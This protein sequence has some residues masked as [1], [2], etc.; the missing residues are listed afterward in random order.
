MSK[1]ALLCQAARLLG[2]VLAH[3]AHGPDL[4]DD[5]GLQLDRTLHSMLTVAL[6]VEV[7]DYDQI[8]FIFRCVTFSLF[9]S[10]IGQSAKGN[11]TLTS[12]LTSLSA[13]VALYT[14]TF[15]LAGTSVSSSSFN[16]DR[17]S[18]AFAVC[19]LVTERFQLPNFT[20]PVCP[21]TSR[22]PE[23]MSLWGCFFA[24]QVCAVHMR[25][26][27]KN[28]EEEEV[29]KFFKEAFKVIDRGWRAAG[30]YG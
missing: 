4:K 27:Q 10:H 1:F 15:Q 23:E 3:V 9:Q 28:G 2:Q 22:P 7:P 26:K 30:E 24:Y 12:K 13:L 29:V 14:P 17:L 19:K 5:V 6:N 18:R 21:L 11:I 16:T 8:T 25:V 20:E